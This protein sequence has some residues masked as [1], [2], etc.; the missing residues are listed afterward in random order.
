MQ[1]W[2]PA[3]TA[4]V[5]PV[6]DR[7]AAD[8]AAC[9]APSAAPADRVTDRAIY[10]ATHREILGWALVVLVALMSYYVHVLHVHLEQAQALHARLRL[11]PPVRALPGAKPAHLRQSYACPKH[12][13]PGT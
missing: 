2:G 3:M 4:S 9:L 5:E 1:A 13:P 6:E 12:C 10:R 11:G 7:S 8:R